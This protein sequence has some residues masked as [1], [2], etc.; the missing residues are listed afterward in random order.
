MFLKKLAG[1][2]LVGLVLVSAAI[3]VAE[4]TAEVEYPKLPKGAGEIAE[5]APKVFS[6]TESGLK[7]RILREG[8]AT[9]PTASQTVEVNYHGWLKDGTVFDSSYRRK[10]TATFPLKG[11]IRGWTEGLQLV[12]EGG[13]IELDIPYDLAYGF[14]GRPPL[15]PR[16]ADLHF[17]VELVE[18][19]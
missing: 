1:L 10:M 4:E 6:K 2:A 9:K 11:V 18:V 5:N 12:G 16:Q 3:S 17:I 8:G 14:N 13:M 15:I 7:Y 19:K